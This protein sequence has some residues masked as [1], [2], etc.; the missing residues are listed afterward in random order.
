MLNR[1]LFVQASSALALGRSVRAFQPPNSQSA[2]S[3]P[4][5]VTIKSVT[6]VNLGLGRAGFLVS[7][8]YDFGN[9]GKVLIKGVGVVPSKDSLSYLTV[10]HDLEFRDPSS[11]AL[12][13]RIPWKETVV[14]AAETPLNDVPSDSDFPSQFVSGKWEPSSSF[15]GR[16]NLVLNKSFNYWPHEADNINYI[17]TTY[18]PLHGTALTRAGL[19]GVIALLISFPFDQS[20]D[21]FWF[22]IKSI[23]KETKPA[24]NVQ[25]STGNPTIAEA[26]RVFVDWLVH[27]LVSK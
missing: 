21:A 18:A 15:L 13:T 9:K 23:V 7:F 1:R 11:D 3:R 26:G 19:S 14:V 25:K 17:S 22:R 27:E 6:K 24:S 4:A 12:L 10:D 20:A 16:A 8:S 2:Q 5:P